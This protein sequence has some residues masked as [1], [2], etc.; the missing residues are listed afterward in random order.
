VI[1]AGA[2]VTNDV[3]AHAVVGGSPAVEI[4]SRDLDV[5]RR[6]REQGSYLDW[7][8]DFD[9]VSGRKLQLRRRSGQGV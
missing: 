8:R 9:M 7:P 1:G 3:A 4:G 5:Y 6:L 2:V